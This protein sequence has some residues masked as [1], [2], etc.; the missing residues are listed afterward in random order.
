M[1][2]RVKHEAIIAGRDANVANDAAIKRYQHARI[3]SQIGFFV[4]PKFENFVHDGCA[5]TGFSKFFGGES[6]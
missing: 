3:I 2:V 4:C 6:L 5:L 1:Q